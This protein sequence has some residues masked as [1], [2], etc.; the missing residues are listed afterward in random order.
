MPL[1]PLFHRVFKGL[2][3]SEGLFSSLKLFLFWSNWPPPMKLL[4]QMC[5]TC[6]HR[7]KHLSVFAVLWDADSDAFYL[8][9]KSKFHRLFILQLRNLGQS[10]RKT[11]GFF[12]MD[13]FWGN[14]PAFPRRTLPLPPGELWVFFTTTISHPKSLWASSLFQKILR[15]VYCFSLLHNII[16]KDSF[17]Q[18]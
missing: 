12:F 13:L 2:K 16:W 14:N 8:K 15:P 9:I 7:H 11:M 4:Q 6:N 5:A 1:W 18:I 3:I 17:Q 10:V